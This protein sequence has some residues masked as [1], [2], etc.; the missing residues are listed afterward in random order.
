VTVTVPNSDLQLRPGMTSE[1]E[2]ISLEVADAL[3]LPK[4][5]IQM[6][7]NRAYVTILDPKTKVQDTQRVRTGADDGTNI[8][9]ESGL[10]PQQTV[11]LPTRA[12]A[13]SSSATIGGN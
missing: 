7:R 8:V 10:E 9:I 3:T 6:V 2:I 13:G 11:V 12:S 1:A 5:A 4:R